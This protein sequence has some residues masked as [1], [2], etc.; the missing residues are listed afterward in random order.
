MITMAFTTT[1]NS[2]LEMS[3]L[4][5]ICENLFKKGCCIVI[6]AD[7]LRVRDG[8]ME[9]MTDGLIRLAAVDIQLAADTPF[10]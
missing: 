7:S 10:G 2:P 6:A 5:S 9:Y 8:H 3:G 4:R 1:K